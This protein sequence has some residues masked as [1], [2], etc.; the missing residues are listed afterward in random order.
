[1]LSYLIHFI[2]DYMTINLGYNFHKDLPYPAFLEI[3]QFY[4][5]VL[6]S[7]FNISFKFSNLEM[8]NFIEIGILDN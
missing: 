3:F 8:S 1:M 6:Q 7:F 2:I 4:F 5:K